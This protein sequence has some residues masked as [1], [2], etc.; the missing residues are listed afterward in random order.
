[1]CST[2]VLGEV[3]LDLSSI[4]YIQCVI[5]KMNLMLEFRYRRGCDLGQ[6]KQKRSVYCPLSPL[7]RCL[8]CWT[9]FLHGNDVDYFVG[10]MLQ[11]KKRTVLS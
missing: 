10:K 4:H 7:T 3:V 2:V 6:K 1:M 11:R 9:S 8:E 5:S